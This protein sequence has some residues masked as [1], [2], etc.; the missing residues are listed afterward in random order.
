[1]EEIRLQKF[2]AE[3]GVASRRKCEE[4]ILD[5]RVFVNGNRVTEL[6]TK[7][8][9]EDVVEVDGKELQP[10]TK[11]VYIALNKPVGYVTTVSDQFDRPTVIDLVCDEIH[12]RI[13]PVGRLDYDTEG[14]LLLTNDG[15]ITYKLTHPKHTIFKTYDVV[16]NEVPNP[17]EIERLKKGVVIDGRK[18]QPAKLNWLKDNLIEISIS[19]GR[20]RQIRKMF[21]AIGYTVVGLKRVSV[22]DISLGNIPLGRWRHLSK[23]EIEYLNSI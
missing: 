21:E 10:I 4:I 22:G 18:T 13:F 6:G 19:E 12:T 8:S 11:K 14:L 2:M 1:M 17:R 23:Y 16:L 15:D 9:E 3:C 20:N 5:G 7:V